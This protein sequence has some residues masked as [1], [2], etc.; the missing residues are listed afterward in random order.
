MLSLRD[1]LQQRRDKG[2]TWVQMSQRT[3]GEISPGVLVKWYQE[4]YRE[5]P[6]VSTIKR[7]ARAAK[8][9]PMT[10]VLGLAKMFGLAETQ[11]SSVFGALLPAEV[12]GLSDKDR[13]EILEFI[14]DKLHAHRHAGT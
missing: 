1:V 6:K 3:G 10:I 11:R 5:F 12:D 13:H 14:H 4:Q 9:D 2:E 7:M 8:T